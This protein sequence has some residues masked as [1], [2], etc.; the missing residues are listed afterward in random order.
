MEN[1]DPET[2]HF[3]VC[4]LYLGDYTLASTFG[5]TTPDE[6][7]D[8]MTS[9]GIPVDPSTTEPATNL[10]VHVKVHL[11]AVGFHCNELQKL[12]KKNLQKLIR[13]FGQTQWFLE[14]VEY[15]FTARDGAGLKELMLEAIA[16]H[17][18][19]LVSEKAEKLIHSLGISHDVLRLVGRPSTAGKKR[20]VTSAKPA[21][22]RQATSPWWDEAGNR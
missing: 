19:W 2:F 7:A 17:Q 15:V 1:A 11:L 10:L 5:R 21:A 3:L 9:N 20:K 22:K 13:R 14:V 4:Y 18:T 16:E 12:A 6:Q 8:G